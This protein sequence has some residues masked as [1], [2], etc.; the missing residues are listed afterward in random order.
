MMTRCDVAIVG[1]G[2]A[3]LAGAI[4][5]ARAG[6]EVVV[7]D[8]NS[9]P[10]GQLF[11]QIHKFFGSHEHYAG[12]R[13]FQIGEELLDQAKDLGV[14]I[15]LDTPVWGLF[16]D[17]K[18]GVMRDGKCSLIQSQK[19]LLA[20][21]AFEKQL[22]FPGW[23]LPGVMGVGAAQTM[24]NLYRV[25]PGKK[26][27]IVGSGNVGLIVA[28]QIIQAGGKIVAVVELAEKVGGYDVHAASLRRRRIPILTQCTVMEARGNGFIEEVITVETDP[29]GRPLRGTERDFAADVLC[30]AVGLTPLAELASMAGCRFLYLPELGGHVPVH[31]RDMQTTVPWIYVAGD[32]AGV[33]EASTAMEEGRLAGLSISESLGLKMNPQ[34]LRSI[35]GRLAELRMGP[36]GQPRTV[37]KQKLLASFGQAMT[38]SDDHPPAKRKPAKIRQVPSARRLRKGPVAVIECMQEIPCNPCEAICPSGAIQVGAPITNLPNLKENL[39]TGCGTCV[40]ACPGRAIF[41]VDQ[42]YSEKNA[43]LQIPYED[44]PLPEIGAEVPVLDRDGNRVGVGTVVDLRRNAAQNRTAIVSL[45]VPREVS[46]R[47]QNLAVPEETNGEDLVICR[48]EDVTLGQIKKAIQ[49]G[50]LTVSWV[51]RMT[52]AG[53]GLC[54]GRT[55]GP[56]VVKIIAQ[57]LHTELSEVAPDTKRPPQRLLSLE[58]LGDLKE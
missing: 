29:M 34:A 28:H 3:G 11:K 7:L 56:Q 1:A 4:E 19:I 20:T 57:E 41:L 48:C 45:V 36:F 46:S 21:G 51:K 12:K 49:E 43:L 39:C 40:A 10:G 16:P 58:E 17:G 47:I 9:K 32:I 8:E 50:A 15:F 27:I 5:V 13:G 55:C 31:G 6:A 14:H 54:Q 33:E 52:R 30:L 22:F 44:L 26:F 38:E 42:T 53:M 37:A 35:R 23:T 2:P 24:I 18:L 25:L